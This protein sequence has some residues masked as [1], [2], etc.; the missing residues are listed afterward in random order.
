MLFSILVVSLTAMP[1]PSIL[2]LQTKCT[3][4]IPMLEQLQTGIAQ[5]Q[6]QNPSL[7]ERL[8]QIYPISKLPT[9]NPS[10]VI[11]PPETQWQH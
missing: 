8:A 3:H 6:Q 2:G 11:R 4:T 9:S 1:F 5:P 7:R 10:A